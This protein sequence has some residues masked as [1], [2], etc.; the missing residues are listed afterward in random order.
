MFFCSD[1]E[2]RRR[3]CAR[4]AAYMAILLGVLTCLS[5]C[6]ERATLPLSAGIGPHPVLPAPHEAL[7][8]TVNISPA[9]GWA[10]GATPVAATGLAVTEFASGLDYPRWLYV[11]PN[12][13]VLV[14]ET[15][16]PQR[17]PGE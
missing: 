1:S 10:T 5:A 14:A 16:A 6:A 12:G 4:R 3:S 9:K 15:N 17:P 13:D 11:L 7:F 2:G 8:A